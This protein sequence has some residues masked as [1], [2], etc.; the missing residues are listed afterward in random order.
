MALEVDDDNDSNT[1]RP[2]RRRDGYGLE[3]DW[4][5]LGVMLYEMAY[6][7]TPFFA[8][9]IRQTY[10]RIMD[11]EVSAMGSVVSV[12]SL[13]FGARETYVSILPLQPPIII[14]TFCVG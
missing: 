12:Y 1:S 5:S 8:K 3:T 4:W 13:R 11:H 2:G 7:V 9:D 14:K 6:G 10:L